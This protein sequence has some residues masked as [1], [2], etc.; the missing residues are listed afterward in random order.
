M[1][2][3]AICG[4][5]N[6]FVGAF[7][8]PMVTEFAGE[9]E[10][11]ALLDVD[12]IRFDACYKQAPSTKGLPTYSEE[13][14][15][16]M[17]DETKPD[18]VVVTG[19]DFTHARY[20][21]AALKRDVNVIVEKPLTID[22]ESCRAILDAERDSKGS[23]TVTFNARFG[24][25]HRT[26]KELILEGKV[27][28]I[29]S[30]DLNYYI[31]SFHGASYLKRWNRMRELSGGLTIHKGTHHFDL[32]NWLVGQDP[33]EVF[34]YAALNYYGPDAEMNPRKVDGR[35]CGGCPDASD[36][37][38]EM[39][40]NPGRRNAVPLEEHLLSARTQK[41]TN[42]R[43]DQ[44]IFDSK[45]NIE[46]TYAVTVRYRHGAMMSYSANFS[47][48]YEGYRLAING[49]RG[50]IETQHIVTR[51]AFTAPE[52]TV[53]YLPLF[54]GA[55]QD[56][57]PLTRK[58]GHGGSDTVLQEYLFVGPEKRVQ[59]PVLGTCRDGAMAVAVGEAVWRSALEHRPVTMAELLGEWADAP[60]SREPV[61]AR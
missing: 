37:E 60:A 49:T 61:T 18:V 41:Y 56:I 6:R 42:Y 46:D 5:S 40:W 29:T 19:A 52:Q 50:R 47:T 28:R 12:P 58:G 13:Q 38:Y 8:G 55:K 11:V 48:P 59:Y 51:G 33:V 43:T 17:I 21:V 30:V 53:T 15:D 34:A 39:R 54:H 4:I 7:L 10:I 23:V 3:Y 1:K 45:I 36:C 2:R 20:C 27:G 16:R 32:V 35:N 57:L 26:I 14:F 24:F 44:C 31:D 9:C 25:H 22:C